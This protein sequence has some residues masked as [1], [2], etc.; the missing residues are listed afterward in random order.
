MRERGEAAG[1]ILEILRDGPRQAQD[2]AAD[3][4]IDTSAVRRHLEGL[5]ADGLV[6]RHNAIEG[7]GRPKTRYALSDAGWETF[8]RDYALVLSLALRK[9]A[10]TH[11]RDAV[12]ALLGSIAADVAAGIPDGDRSTRVDALVR[13]YNDL[14][15]EA[16]VEGGGD[17]VALVQRNCIA[18][19]TARADP[20]AMCECFDEGI[21]RAA[22]PNAD[23]TLERTMAKGDTLCRHRL[24]FRGG[25]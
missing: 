20:D 2:V 14:G 16:H 23:V 15:F 19:R 5:R 9:L 13:I 1:R 25:A 4:G 17:D 11:G 3:L 21:L 18:L 22:F 6:T 12:L 24:R 8:P 7:P 10:D